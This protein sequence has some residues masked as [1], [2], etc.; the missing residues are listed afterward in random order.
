[1]KGAIFYLASLFASHALL[2]QEIVTFKTTLFG[3]AYSSKELHIC[4][5]SA[6]LEEYKKDTITKFAPFFSLGNR[7]KFLL[8]EEKVLSSLSQYIKSKSENIEK[9]DFPQPFSQVYYIEI[10]DCKTKNSIITHAFGHDKIKI[11]NFLD[12]IM[13]LY[14]EE[15]LNLNTELIHYIRMIKSELKG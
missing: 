12:Q 4:S 11:I 10:F 5:D 8:V 1:M 9:G 15:K 3:N 6:I 7:R 2:G 14:E 13:A